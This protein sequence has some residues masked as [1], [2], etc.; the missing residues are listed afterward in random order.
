VVLEDLEVEGALKPNLRTG[1][2]VREQ[3][4]MLRARGPELLEKM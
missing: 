3:R 4:Y 1:D 2:V